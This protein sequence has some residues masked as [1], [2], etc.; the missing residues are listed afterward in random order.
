VI[1]SLVHHL[2]EREYIAGD[3]VSLQPY[4]LHWLSAAAGRLSLEGLNSRALA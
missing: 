3:A 2:C 1:K 4:H